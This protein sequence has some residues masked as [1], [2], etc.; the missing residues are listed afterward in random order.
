MTLGHFQKIDSYQV[1]FFFIHVKFKSNYGFQLL[2]SAVGEYI[3]IQGIYGDNNI[4]ICVPIQSNQ[5][6]SNLLKITKS[7]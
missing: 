6:Y 3:N 7:K 4:G 1:Y 2:A 5:I